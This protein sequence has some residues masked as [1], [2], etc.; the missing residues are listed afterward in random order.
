SVGIGRTCFVNAVGAPLC[1]GDTQNGTFGIGDSNAAA[2][3]PVPVFGMGAGEASAQAQGAGHGCVLTSGGGVRC[4]GDD[5]FGQLGDGTITPGN[6]PV[7]VVGIQSGASG[8][9]IG[10]NGYTTCVIVTGAE[11]RCWGYGGLGGLGNNTASNSS[12][13]VSP[14]AFDVNGQF[15]GDYQNAAGVAVGT[16]HTCAVT[17][18]GAVDCW[19]WNAAGEVGNGTRDSIAWPVRVVGLDS[20]I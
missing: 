13:P 10:S 20:G 4:S 18:A 8:L 1:W 9:S 14:L 6:T 5:Q 15:V 17:T 2:T 19:G 3:V 16:F 12:V 7:D 11:I